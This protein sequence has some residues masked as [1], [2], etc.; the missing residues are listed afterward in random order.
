ME[1]LYVPLFWC[2]ITRV[3]AIQETLLR[4]PSG[5]TEMSNL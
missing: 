1:F 4:Y 3:L 5:A 2:Q